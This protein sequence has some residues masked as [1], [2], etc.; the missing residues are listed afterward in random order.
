M[1]QQH[2][3]ICLS[4]DV[5][6]W[7]APALLSNQIKSAFIKLVCLFIYFKVGSSTDK[8]SYAKGKKKKR[9]KRRKVIIIR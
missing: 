5:S 2:K 4:N 1:E 8:L 9:K 3:L 6:V 7:V